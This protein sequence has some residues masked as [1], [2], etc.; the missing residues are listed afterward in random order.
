[1]R[2]FWTLLVVGVY[3]IAILIRAWWLLILG[4]PGLV[5]NIYIWRAVLTRR[6]RLRV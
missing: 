2:V 4:L 1:M 5:A 6:L 3:V